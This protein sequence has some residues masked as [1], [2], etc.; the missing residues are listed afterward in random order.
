MK[1]LDIYTQ[2]R[3]IPSLQLHMFRVAA[4]TKVIAENSQEEVDVPE[5]ISACLLHDMGNILKFNF[6]LFP[7]FF[8][9]EG[10]DY[11]KGIRKLFSEKYGEDERHATIVIAQEIGVSERTLALIQAIG[12]SNAV[13]NKNHTDFS[14]KICAYADTRV[15]PQGVVSLAE[16]LEDGKKRFQLNKKQQ[17]NEE[18]FQQ[19]SEAM[20]EIEKQIFEINS[21]QPQD[22][23][24]E[25]V[26]AS[27]EELKSFEII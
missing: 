4:V 19:M 14:K 1:I 10:L 27:V 7:E 16:R 24:D 11:W 5:I 3:I 9:P 17:D 23:T 21:L 15:K 6:D 2:H 22:I 25:Q 8:Q 12:F 18:F 26:K 13:L 20:Y